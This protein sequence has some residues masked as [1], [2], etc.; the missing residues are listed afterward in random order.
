MISLPSCVSLP[1]RLRLLKA[2]SGF[3]DCNQAG[4]QG[5]LFGTVALAPET[6]A[7]EVKRCAAAVANKVSAAPLDFPSPVGE[8][9]DSA[10]N[11]GDNQIVLRSDLLDRSVLRAPDA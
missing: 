8:L 2:V 4:G 7:A 10:L 5:A 3:A 11:P 6:L 1:P 9:L